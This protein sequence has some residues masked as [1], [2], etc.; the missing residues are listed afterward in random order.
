MKKRFEVDV[1]QQR[2]AVVRPCER[3]LDDIACRCVHAEDAN[4][5]RPG[6]EPRER[7]C[8]VR[9]IDLLGLSRLLRACSGLRAR[10]PVVGFGSLQKNRESGQ[11]SEA[12][13]TQRELTCAGKR[14]RGSVRRRV[15][16]GMGSGSL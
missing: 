13:H 4:V 14:A 10:F 7:L 8:A 15:P 9:T 5:R 6:R 3:V 12:S 1:V 2:F 16:P 11:V